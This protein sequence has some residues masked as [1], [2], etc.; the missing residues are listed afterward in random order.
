MVRARYGPESIPSQQMERSDGQPVE[1]VRRFQSTS[2]D[3][4]VSVKADLIER[5]KRF[6]A[7]HDYSESDLARKL[8]VSKGLVDAWFSGEGTPSLDAA[9]RIRRLKHGSS[10]AD[11]GV[12]GI[13]FR[14]GNTGTLARKQTDLGLALAICQACFCCSG[15]SLVSGRK[16]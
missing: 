5:L 9:L 15:S 6:G 16:A 11:C 13:S 4:K 10:N 14:R 2:K 12:S 8:K 7:E 1:G 3:V